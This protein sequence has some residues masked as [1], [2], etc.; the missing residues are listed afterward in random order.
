MPFIFLYNRLV[1]RVPITPQDFLLFSQDLINVGLSPYVDMKK[2][3]M[4]GL[5]ATAIIS[6][7]PELEGS[8]SVGLFRFATIDACKEQE[9]QAKS[10]SLMSNVTRN[11]RY[12]MSCTFTPEDN[13]LANKVSNTFKNCKPFL[14]NE[15]TA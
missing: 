13:D 14:D 15:K 9:K 7:N 3:E 6:F 4:H 12:L 5:E 11:G 10:N 2:L 1:L 8:R